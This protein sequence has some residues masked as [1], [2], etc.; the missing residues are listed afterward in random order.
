MSRQRQNRED[1]LSCC[2]FPDEYDI[3]YASLY[4]T[5]TCVRMVTDRDCLAQMLLQPF[6]YIC[7][8]PGKQI[9]PK[10]A[11]SFNYW[12]AVPAEKLRQIEQIVEM[13]HN[14]SLL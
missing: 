6:H 9:R 3:S 13:L 8:T 10:L 7:Q 12:L 4:W 2:L 14:A 11:Q 5:L 1:S